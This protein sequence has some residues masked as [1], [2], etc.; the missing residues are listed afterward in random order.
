MIRYVQMLAW[1]I[2]ST[3]TYFLLKEACRFQER[4]L[5]MIVIRVLMNAMFSLSI[6]TIHSYPFLIGWLMQIFWDMVMISD[7]RRKESKGVIFW[8]HLVYVATIESSWLLATCLFGG[9]TFS[10]FSVEGNPIYA[11]LG[12]ICSI[13]VSGLQFWPMMRFNKNGFNRKISLLVIGMMTLNVL[14]VQIFDTIGINS[15]YFYLVI[16]LYSFLLIIAM[17]FLINKEQLQ[18]K[19]AELQATEQAIANANVKIE[20]QSNQLREIRHSLKD[21][22]RIIQLLNRQNRNEEVDKY[23]SGLIGECNVSHFTFYCQDIVLNALFNQMVA[24]HTKIHF[25]LLVDSKIDKIPNE[26][27]EAIFLAIDNA[28]DELDRHQDLPKTITVMLRQDQGKVIGTIRNPLFSVKSLRT[29]KTGQDHGIGLSRM[30]KLLND[31]DGTIQIDQDKQFVLTMTIP[32]N[33]I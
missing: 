10:L 15:I 22:M 2:K 4:R 31:L 26:F 32:M 28:I 21:H 29:E 7:L 30:K 3:S 25:D 1:I 24:T 27:V 13:F 11:L 8:R 9:W 16:V 19:E 18:K 5:W 17:Q 14:S 20:D 6:W 23:L 33:K 12:M